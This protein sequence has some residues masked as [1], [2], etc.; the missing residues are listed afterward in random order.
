[1]EIYKIKDGLYSLEDLK[2]LVKYKKLTEDQ[3]F[4]ITRFNY[5]AVV[6]KLQ[7]PD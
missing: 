7:N 3:F 1:M 4:E 2:I 5:A 6:Q